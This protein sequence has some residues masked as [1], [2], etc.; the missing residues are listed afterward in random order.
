MVVK[1]DTLDEAEALMSD[2]AICKKPK[3]NIDAHYEAGGLHWTIG[4]C[5]AEDCEVH[6]HGHVD[7]TVVIDLGDDENSATLIGVN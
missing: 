2:C 4:R 3:F 6:C 5:E 1:C 7:R